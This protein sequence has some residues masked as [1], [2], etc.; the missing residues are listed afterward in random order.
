MALKILAAVCVVWWFVPTTVA[1][2]QA[3]CEEWNTRAFFEK[4]AASDVTRCL[5]G[6]GAEVMH[7]ISTD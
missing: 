7:G 6:F 4:A 3:A 5:A 2:A 1:V